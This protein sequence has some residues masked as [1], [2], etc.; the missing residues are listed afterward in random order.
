V[1]ITFADLLG[2]YAECLA[3]GVRRV[4]EAAERL[5]AVN[6]GG[7]IVGRRSDVPEPYFK[8]IIPCLREAAD[9]PKY[10]MAANLF[11]A[12]QNPDDLV[13]VSSASDLLAR[14]L[15]KICRDL[16]LM[17]SG[18]EGG[19]GEIRLPPVQ[20]GSSIM[21]GKINPVIPEFA[22]QLCF[23]VI[24][25]HVACQ[26]AVDHGELDLNVWE[27]IVVFN[28]LDSINLLSAASSALA[29]KCVAGLEAVPERNCRNIGTIIPLLTQL[30]QAHGY[31]RISALCKQARGDTKYLRE[32]LRKDGLL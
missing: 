19:L 1:E 26:A 8:A 2:G 31:S 5:H 30:A 15:V 12:A 22:M 10:E 20:P 4:A 29:G 14:S 3:R 13:A 28:V 7:S 27:S 11:D 32:I 18:P 16:R 9:D 17:S 6:L 21:P 24:G 25:N 23:Q